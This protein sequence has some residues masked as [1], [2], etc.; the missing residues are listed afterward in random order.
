M[1]ERF[2]LTSTDLF[3][4]TR[5][6]R[7]YTFSKLL[8][9]ERVVLR[10]AFNTVHA[11]PI[12]A[13]AYSETLN[14]IATSDQLGVI[15]LY[16][17]RGVL[18]SS[19][20]LASGVACMIIL[21]SHIILGLYDGHQIMLR[22]NNTKKIKSALERWSPKKSKC[23]VNLIVESSLKVHTSEIYCMVEWKGWIITG[24]ADGGISIQKEIKHVFKS[25]S[26]AVTCLNVIHDTLYSGSLDGSII[27]WDLTDK[28]LVRLVGRHL[29]G[30]K[31]LCS[32]SKFLISSGWDDYICGIYILVQSCSNSCLIL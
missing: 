24:C 16:S 27:K 14:L 19:I 20:T 25:H 1:I 31:S 7:V 28:R 8:F 6:H 18:L 10:D 4:F 2:I 23:E 17:H 3:V 15:C 26:N 30:I 5:R 13:Y 21:H 29:H 22:Q 32:N 11:A 9:E 12:I